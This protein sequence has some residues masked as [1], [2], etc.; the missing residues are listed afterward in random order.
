M[1]IFLYQNLLKITLY[2]KIYLTYWGIIMKSKY[3]INSLNICIFLSLSLLLLYGYYKYNILSR[4]NIILISILLLIILLLCIKFYLSKKNNLYNINAF[5]IFL[6]NIILLY[7]LINLNN[8]YAYITSIFYKNSYNTYEVYV[9]KTNVIYNNLNKLENKN[10]GILTT[11]QTNV[12]DY[13]NKLEN[14]N[15]KTYNSIYDLNNAI[16]NGEI[17]AIIISNSY[18]EELNKV[19]KN[20]KL[21]SIYTSRIKENSN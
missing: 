18:K 2:I 10:I 17:Q 19:D 8:Q 13:Y 5:I 9:K 21:K 20:S 7:N 14:Y 1:I 6:I 3:L 15:Y 11:N 16:N 4:I 12:I